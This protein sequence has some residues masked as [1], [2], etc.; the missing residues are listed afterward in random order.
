[1]FNLLSQMSMC[2]CSNIYESVF[3]GEKKKSL[4]LPNTMS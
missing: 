1:M 3:D 2:L 4:K